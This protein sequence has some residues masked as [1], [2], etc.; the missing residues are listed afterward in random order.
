[1]LS[2]VQRSIWE[3]KKFNKENLLERELEKLGLGCRGGVGG[4]VGGKLKVEYWLY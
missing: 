3:V 4:V 2:F 1:M